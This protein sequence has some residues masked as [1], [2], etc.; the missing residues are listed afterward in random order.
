MTVTVGNYTKEATADDPVFT[1]TVTGLRRN[2]TPAVITYTVARA[3][4][5]EEGEYAIT[6]TGAVYQ[7]NY[8]VTYV[9]GTLT[10]TAEEIE[11][12]RVPLATPVPEDIIDEPVPQAAPVA[13]TWALINLI[14]AILTTAVGLV[15]AV[16]FFKK[17]KEDEE[18]EE[19]KAVTEEEEEEK[20]KRRIGKFFGLL[21]ALASIITF[22]LTEDM[23]AKMALVDKWTILMVVF[24]AVNAVLG[25]VTRNK[26]E[27]EQEQ[28]TANV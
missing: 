5:E 10:I 26:K 13:Q 18:A 22:I 12:P 25:L 8:V 21:P 17:K 24:L 6:P 19:T 20:S 15:M 3:E 11:E 1:A 2:D 9:P 28:E 7:G 23:S 16:T 14:C 27:E 4:G